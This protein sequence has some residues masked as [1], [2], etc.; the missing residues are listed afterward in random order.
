MRVTWEDIGRATETGV[1][2]VNS[3]LVNV[4]WKDIEVWKKNP[5]AVFNAKLYKPTGMYMLG[6]HEE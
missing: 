2:Q 1:Y 5:D 3:K 4:A 6:S